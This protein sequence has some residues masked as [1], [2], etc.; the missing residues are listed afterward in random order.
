MLKQQI[1]NLIMTQLNQNSQNVL[2]S[3]GQLGQTNSS[4]FAIERFGD[5]DINPEENWYEVITE[6]FVPV[7]VNNFDA[8]YLFD[9]QFNRQTFSTRFSFLIKFEEQNDVLNAVNTY[10]ENIVGTTATLSVSADVSVANIAARNAL[11]NLTVGD[12]IFVA[13][14]G[15]GSYAHYEVI[16]TDP[17]IVFTL[18]N[19]DVYTIFYQPQDIRFINTLVL[20]DIKFLEF[21]LPMTIQMAENAQFGADFT[22]GIKLPNENTYTSL[23]IISYLPTRATQTVPVQYVGS[24]STRSIAQASSWSAVL[25]FYLRIPN[26]YNSSAVTSL[27]TQ[28]ENS[29]QEMNT[30]YNLRIYNPLAQVFYDKTVIISSI[31]MPVQK[32]NIVTMTIVLE[33]AN[34]GVI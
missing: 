29:S 15:D 30:L 22:I 8:V 11:E 24:N 20:N 14:N 10:I 2:F 4:T 5:S 33:E 32:Q 31:N 12:I 19:R 27:I 17:N 18:V 1:Q 3:L 9:N 21:E 34:E 13:D 28:L 16:N 6:E 26:S 25:E 7:V 23:N